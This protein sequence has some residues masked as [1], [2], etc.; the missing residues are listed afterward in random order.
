L[1]TGRADNCL[2]TTNLQI[3]II[4]DTYDEEEDG[5]GTKKKRKKKTHR[6]YAFIVYER[7]KDMKGTAF[8]I[9]LLT[10]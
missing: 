10:A 4:K 6:G 3:R 5:D 8:P 1:P 2:L 7:E 9:L